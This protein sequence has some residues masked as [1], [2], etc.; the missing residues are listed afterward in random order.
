M[1]LSRKNYHTGTPRTSPRFETKR[2]CRNGS[3]EELP[4]EVLTSDGADAELVREKVKHARKDYHTGTPRTS[5]R[6][7]LKRERHKG[8]VEE[9]AADHMRFRTLEELIASPDNAESA[10]T[11]ST[12][13]LN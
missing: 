7:Q 9:L 2:G 12:D 1:K 4:A 6:F 3:V 8:P 5:P 13:S 10:K 11:P